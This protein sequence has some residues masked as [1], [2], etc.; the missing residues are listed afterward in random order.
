MTATCGSSTG[1]SHVR[2][3]ISSRGIIDIIGAVIAI[4]PIVGLLAPGFYDLR[5]ETVVVV[6]PDE[7]QCPG[8]IEVE[9][10]APSS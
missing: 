9:G 10:T 6:I 2:R 3:S 5:P 8:S 4:L 1:I 7:S